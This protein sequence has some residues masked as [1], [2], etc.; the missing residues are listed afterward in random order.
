MTE[1]HTFR[2]VYMGY[3]E[4]NPYHYPSIDVQHV[5]ASKA[6]HE[7]IWTGWQIFP[8]F[9]WRHVCT[10]AQWC[11]LQTSAEEICL[12]GVSL[13]LYNPIPI[14]SNLSINRT[15]T[16]AAFNNCVYGM[17]YEDNL[18][19]T[20][21]FLW[22]QLPE[23]QE[24]CLAHREGLI[25]TGD[26]TNTGVNTPGPPAYTQ[27]KYIWPQYRWR[28]PLTRTD[29]DAVWSQ[30]LTGQA[31]VYNVYSG[32]DQIIVPSGLFWDPLNRPEEIREL[33][34]GKNSI[35]M[36]WNVQSIDEGKWQN[37]DFLAAYS[38][39][40]V[41]GPYCGVGRPLQYKRS[42]MHDPER[43]CTY[44]LAQKN[45]SGS[46]GTDNDQEK[47]YQDYTVP[48]YAYLP[49]FPPTWFWQEIKSTVI[50]IIP[51]QFLNNTANYRTDPWKKAD[52]YWPGPEATSYTHS[53]PQWF[54]KGIPIFDENDARI[55]TLTHLS[56]CIEL[57]FEYKK[58]RTAYYGCTWG[59]I[60][61]E[62][63][64]YISPE[65][66]IYQ[67]NMIKYKTAGRR[68]PWQNMNTYNTTLM[69]GAGHGGGG[70]AKS[71]PREDCFYMGTL[72][73]RQYNVQ[74]NPAGMP[75]ADGH[76]PE[77]KMSITLATSTMTRDIA[78]ETDQQ[79]PP[80]PRKPRVTFPTGLATFHT[81]D[82]HL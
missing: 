38:A 66:L 55:K 23:E 9:L 60:S 46:L 45:K 25:W 27:K 68:L 50:D 56:A 2:N 42:V 24:L 6:L 64:Y 63:M 80:R 10:P 8:N 82:S 26:D 5:D 40:T 69:E 59:P 22:Q 81:Q 76:N 30:G 36:T 17:F 57:H 72:N 11:W 29:F 71:H 48:N 49:L 4:N 33:R 13:T 61:G 16:F 41:P 32:D 77:P 58:R 65:R 70:E 7:Y 39:W 15:S 79:K 21:W 18:Y 53:I 54:G 34:A 52:K 3:L 44:G 43:A 47:F 14:T 28:R 78:M 75:D 37:L 19:E 67:P 62:Q 12:K 1:S 20:D 73:D 35:K 51:E 31:G 74:H